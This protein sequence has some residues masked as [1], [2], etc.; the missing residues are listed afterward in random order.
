MT[1]QS[2]LIRIVSVTAR[3]VWRAPAAHL[4]ANIHPGRDED[5]EE[6]QDVD[7]ELA[8][9]SITETV[10]SARPGIVHI[11]EHG[12]KLI[13]GVLAARTVGGASRSRAE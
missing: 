1:S 4:V 9:E 5:G 13:H 10:A 12:E 2:H 11:P 3:E 7:G 8:V 6:D